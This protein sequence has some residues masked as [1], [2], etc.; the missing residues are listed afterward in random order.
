MIVSAL[1]LLRGL[2]RV[3]A[4]TLLAT[5]VTLVVVAST[6]RYM[7]VP[8]IWAIEVVQA[9]F[10]WLCVLAAD[11]TL[12]RAGHFSVDMVAN[13]LP[14]RARQALEMF[15]TLLAAALLAGL[16]WYGFLFAYITSGRPLPMTGVTSA[17]ATAALPVGFV[18]MLITLAEQL[19]ARL[20]GRPP[21]A[22]ADEAREVM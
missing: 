20:R 16:A 6:A 3:L 12:Q 21:V 14:P 2:E 8:V 1:A 13:M 17:F 19:V 5:T 18:L 15:N 11:M 7:G 10:V 22:A 9:L 4:S